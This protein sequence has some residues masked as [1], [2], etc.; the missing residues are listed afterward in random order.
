VTVIDTFGTGTE[1]P[2]NAVEGRIANTPAD[3]ADD[4]YVIIPSFS[5]R[6]RWG[7]CYFAPKAGQLPERDDPCLVVF[8]EAGDPWVALWWNGSPEAGGGG[9]ASYPPGGD[10][11][12][13][14]TFVGPDDN[15][16]TWALGTPG[17]EGPSGP[18][19]PK[20]DTGSAGPQG[21]KGDTGTTGATGSQGPKG[22]TG[23]T[24]AQ[25]PAGATGPAGPEGPRGDPGPQGPQG[26]KGD[27]GAQ[28]PQGPQG[29]QGPVGPAG[30]V[31]VSVTNATATADSGQ[32]G[33]VLMLLPL[34]VTL[35]CKG[36]SPVLLDTNA[37]IQWNASWVS[38]R[39]AWRPA[40]GAW[41][42]RTNQGLVWAAG[43]GWLAGDRVT[44]PVSD[45][46][47][48]PSDGNYEFAL[49]GQGG[50]ANSA[51]LLAQ[52]TARITRFQ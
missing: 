39:W 36:G 32:I 13:V 45:F 50:V 12:E 38:I 14:L 8:D 44:V 51:Y 16:V 31:A 48:P 7:P 15:D 40:G 30:T 1:A 4:L 17:P 28:G 21:P 29:D 3:A 5:V 10:P 43:G 49:W 34:S 33:T 9:G 52:T 42:N 25:G 23:A 27:T 47:V 26:V 2:P 11:G 6:Q 18:Q 24:G 22:D 37:I 19:G 46:V 20:G 35:A 41:T